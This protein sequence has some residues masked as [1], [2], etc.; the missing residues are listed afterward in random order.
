MLL[1]DGLRT[2]SVR[3]VGGSGAVVTGVTVRVADWGELPLGVCV[4]L[5]KPNTA[6]HLLDRIQYRLRKVPPK[7][8]GVKLPCELVSFQSKK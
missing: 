5:C 1:S 2:V 4:L 7:M 6:S 8:M 3:P